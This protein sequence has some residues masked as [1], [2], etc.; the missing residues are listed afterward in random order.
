MDK[1]I[2]GVMSAL[3]MLE[4]KSWPAFHMIWCQLQILLLLNRIEKKPVSV[5]RRPYLQNNT[6]KR[7]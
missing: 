1:S 2:S 5:I 3:E 7:L 6:K 4:K